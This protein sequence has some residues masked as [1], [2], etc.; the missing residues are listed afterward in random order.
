MSGGRDDPMR[1]DRTA[2]RGTAEGRQGIVDQHSWRRM[3]FA[4]M[5][6]ER[7]PAGWASRIA[8]VLCEFAVRLKIA[9]LAHNNH[10]ELPM[11]QDQLADA[12]GLTPVH[13]NRTIKALEADQFINRPIH[14]PYTTATGAGWRKAGDFDTTYLHLRSHEPALQ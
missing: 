6:H 5:G 4:R 1:G 3:D 7:R 12:P 13:V 2:V 9:G 14:V 11:T 8:H 10:C